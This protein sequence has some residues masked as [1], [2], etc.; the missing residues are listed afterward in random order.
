MKASLM[1]VE[2]SN[3]F[4]YVFHG[5]GCVASLHTF[6]QKE[7]DPCLAIKD[8]ENAFHFQFSFWHTHNKRVETTRNFLFKSTSSLLNQMILANL[9]VCG[10]KT[11]A[12]LRSWPAFSS[13][14]RQGIQSEEKKAHLSRRDT[15]Q[16]RIPFFFV[17]SLLFWKHRC[18][19]LSYCL[20]LFLLSRLFYLSVCHPFWCKLKSWTWS[21]KI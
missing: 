2:K 4:C 6:D 8:A 17:I 19:R 1:T 7:Q 14:P 16:R 12:K 20:S 21:R 9:Q 3:R 13:T 5:I 15:H 10:E 11:T 18:L